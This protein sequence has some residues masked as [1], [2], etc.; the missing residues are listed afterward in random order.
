MFGSV[1]S[2]ERLGLPRTGPCLLKL[3]VDEV[4]GMSWTVVL[5]YASLWGPGPGVAPALA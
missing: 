5:T 3:G 1:V 4:S 2:R